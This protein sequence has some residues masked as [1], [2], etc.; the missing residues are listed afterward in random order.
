MQEAFDKHLDQGEVFDTSTELRDNGLS[1][2]CSFVIG[3]EDETPE[4]ISASIL[5]GARLKLLGAEIVAAGAG[6]DVLHHIVALTPT[7]VVALGQSMGNELVP[8]FYEVLERLGGIRR[9][10][11]DWAEGDLWSNWEAIRP[12]LDGLIATIDDER[13]LTLLTG[14]VDYEEK[15]LRF[16]KGDWS[17][18]E[19]ASA[20]GDGWVVF[21]SSVNASQI[22]A[23]LAAAQ[24]LE[25][26]VLQPILVVLARPAGGGFASYGLGMEML[27]KL[28]AKDPELI[29][30]LNGLTQ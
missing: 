16:T 20:A 15:R 18:G 8:R 27:P 29:E 7:T 24:P 1:C 30:A 14:L 21:P 4:E 13:S 10:D 12:W 22:A 19:G 25:D 17:D 28:E 2:T 3:F 23:K 11:L 5:S 9:E 6:R 26:D